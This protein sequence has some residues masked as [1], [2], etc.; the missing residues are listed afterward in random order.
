MEAFV[1]II[2][3]IDKNLRRK[4]GIYKFAINGKNYIGSAIDLYQRLFHHRKMILRNY[5]RNTK[6]Q[7]YFN[8]YK[9]FSYEILEYCDKESLIKREQFYLDEQKPDLNILKIAG[10]VYGYKHSEELKEK[11]RQQNLGKKL[12]KEHREKIAEANKGKKLSENHKKS[13]SNFQKG[14]SKHLGESN[15]MS[16]LTNNQVKEICGL[17]KEGLRG[18]KIA[19]LFDV[20][21][22]TIYD[23]KNGKTYK[24]I[25]QNEL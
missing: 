17:I 19:Q 4:S 16:V 9:Q 5:H 10:S 13:I 24:I 25:T 18:V 21:P 8:K 20:N 14:K 11:R 6:V 23:I 22:Q 12:S 3:E 1:N 7:N 15:P 2:Q